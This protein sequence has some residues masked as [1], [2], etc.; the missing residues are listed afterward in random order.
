MEDL[1]KRSDAIKA[2]RSEARL[3][4]S[5]IAD[6]YADMFIFAIDCLPTANINEDDLFE[7]PYFDSDTWGSNDE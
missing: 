6:E 5:A 3:A 7:I 1:I 2:I 4:K